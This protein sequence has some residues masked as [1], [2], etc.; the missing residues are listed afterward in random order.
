MS[1]MQ[2][3]WGVHWREV[4]LGSQHVESLKRK[5]GV[6]MQIVSYQEQM[7]CSESEAA[8]IL[9]RYYF[10]AQVAVM[11]TEAAVFRAVFKGV[12]YCRERE[13]RMTST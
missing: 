7:P 5:Y 3:E 1:V 10:A 4:N 8:L 12:S 2:E 9:Y 13:R 11:A 6:S